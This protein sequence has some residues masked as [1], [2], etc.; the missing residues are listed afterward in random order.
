MVI[1]LLYVTITFYVFLCWGSRVHLFFH[2]TRAHNRISLTMGL[3]DRRWTTGSGPR[4]TIAGRELFRFRSSTS[5]AQHYQGGHSLPRRYHLAVLS[6][7]ASHTPNLNRH[8]SS[9]RRR[10]LVSALH[11]WLVVARPRILSPGPGL[12][13]WLVTYSAVG[14]SF[15]LAE[16]GRQREGRRCCDQSHGS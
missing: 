12:M 15:R 7:R 4:Q 8:R 5:S 16:G 1:V 2:I 9:D 13:A 11:L 6:F 14:M 10:L 3:D